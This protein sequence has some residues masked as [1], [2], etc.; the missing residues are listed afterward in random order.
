MVLVRSREM[1]WLLYVLLFC[2]TLMW[3]LFEP[4]RSAAVPNITAGPDIVVA[5]GLS[6]TTWSFNFAIGSALGGFVAAIFGRN[7]VFVINSLSFVLSATLIARMRFEE[8]HAANL[9]PMRFGE[10]TDFTPILE[11]LRY[12][13]RNVRLAVT[14][15][16]KTGLSFMGT[17]WVIIPI[18]GERLFPLH[19]DGFNARQAST[20]GMSVMLA[21]RGVGAVLGAFATSS[22]VGNSKPRLR[23]SILAGFLLAAAGYLA[24][25]GVPDIW[26]ACAALMVAHAG[27]SIIWTASTTLL[28]EQTED[29]FRGRV[30]SAEFAFSM[31]TLAVISYA[32]GVLVDRGVS[33]RALAFATGLL[34]LIPAAAWANAQKL[35][36]PDR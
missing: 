16:V 33:V 1:V 2:E 31:A 10:V 11:G 22:I 17:N 30:F 34:I 7:T 26:L 29:R 4:A 12:V 9:P 8:P 13:T 35:W 15:F 27:G 24:L 36:K 23:H 3:A 18:M 32:G 20:M 6:S 21:S 19:I 14:M 25:S 28:M 5:N